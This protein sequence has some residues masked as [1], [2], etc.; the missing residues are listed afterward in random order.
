[1]TRDRLIVRAS[2]PACREPATTLALADPL[3]ERTRPMPERMMD[4][5]APAPGSHERAATDEVRV[6]QPATAQTT[7]NAFSAPAPHRGLDAP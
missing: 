6:A 1:V 5:D 2:Y 3:P 7:F 4:S